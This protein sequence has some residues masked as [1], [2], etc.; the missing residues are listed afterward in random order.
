MRICR[1]DGCERPVWARGWCGTHYRRWSKYG[2][3]NRGRLTIIDRLP[4]KVEVG[5][6]WLWT[7]HRAAN[8]Y[9]VTSVEHRPTGAH[10]A[11]WEALV[12]P[13]P[14]GMELDHR[15]RVRHCVNPDHLEPVTP[16]ENVR[17]SESVFG[18]NARKTMCPQGHAYAG[19]N[20]VMEQ[21]SRICRTCK[22]AKLQR[23]R[24]RRRGLV[25]A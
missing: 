7:G 14:D 5:D 18:R 21:G 19:D 11:I 22:L 9:G 20:I 13:I 15:C 3:P 23:M 4:D 17:R 16:A 8:G 25:A 24:A 12:G 6:C 1:V 2:D 10:R